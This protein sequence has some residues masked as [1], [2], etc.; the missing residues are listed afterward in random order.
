MSVWENIAFGLEVRGVPKPERR[1]RAQDS[2]IS[3]RCPTRRTS[4]STNCPA[5]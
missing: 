4:A 3:S 2:S 5:A 1:K